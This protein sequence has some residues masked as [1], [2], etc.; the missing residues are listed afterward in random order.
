MKPNLFSN[1]I[2]E[3]KPN[4]YRSIRACHYSNERVFFPGQF[5]HWQVFV[6]QKGTNK[7]NQTVGDIVIEEAG[8]PTKHIHSRLRE[9]P[10][11]VT[12]SLELCWNAHNGIT[13]ADKSVQHFFVDDIMEM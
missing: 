11:E 10:D 7:K 3:K 2:C 5:L 6:H 1:L 4:S 8:I 13:K 12:G 9:K